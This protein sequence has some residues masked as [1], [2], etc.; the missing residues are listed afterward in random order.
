MERGLVTMFFVK[1]QEDI[2]LSQTIETQ[3]LDLD[4]SKI[5]NSMKKL[6]TISYYCILSVMASLVN[7][8]CAGS[9][10]IN[11][12]NATSNI[13]PVNN[14]SSVAAM[15]QS[16]II[17]NVEKNKQRILISEDNKSSFRNS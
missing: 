9:K 12:S 8:N 16:Q 5:F 11:S 6:K 3:I 2:S 13:D 14:T 15:P 10:S 17:S 1:F 4:V 7:T